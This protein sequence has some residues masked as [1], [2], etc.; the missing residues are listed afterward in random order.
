MKRRGHVRLEGHRLV[1]DTGPFQALGASLMWGAWGF[2]NDQPRLRQN[3]EFLSKNGFH[4]IRVLGVVGDPDRPDYWD[5]R[6][7]DANG[8]DY[9][10][11][12]A[13]LTD[14]AYDEYG[15][16]VEWTLIGDGQIT[17]P[18]EPERYALI[19]RFLAMSATRQ[20]KIMHFEIANEAW[21][22]G[23]AGTDGILQLRTLTR[24]MN[25]RTDLL[26][27]ASAP[28]GPE[29]SDTLDI[30][31][32]GVADLATIHFDRDVSRVEGS[33]RPVRQPWEHVYCEG[34]PVGSNNEPIGPGASV[35]SED[36]PE[37]LVAAAIA[38]YV[39][40]LPMYVFHTDAGVRG[41]TDLFD[42][43]GA[44]AFRNLA[45]V[46]PNDLSNWSRR[47][48][49]WSDSPFVVF[50]GENGQLYPNEMW[51]DRGA[52]ESGVVRAYG[53]VQGDDFFVFP[54]GILNHA[55]MEARRNMRFDVIDPMSGAVLATHDLDAGERVTL[56]GRNALVLKGR[57]LP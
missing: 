53:S 25:D 17:V 41:M 19:D 13:G 8:P 23:F 2:K 7:V 39:S 28:S 4:Y 27:A 55:E 26:V 51:V 47:N 5:G 50:A 49:H 57:F 24:Y 30:Y 3:L 6:E 42:A 20:E 37:K 38:T 12:I 15:L 22:N 10:Q 1:D 31:A 32:G 9:D 21:Q 54:I 16:R 33:W 40:N 46:V 36:D 34:A 35:A 14:M 56:Q 52:P 48:A 45:A 44:D 43:P 29:C 11:V 18:S